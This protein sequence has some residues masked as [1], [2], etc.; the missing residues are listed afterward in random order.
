M[1]SDFPCL[2]SQHDLNKVLK[3]VREGYPVKDRPQLFK[4]LCDCLRKWS[5]DSFESE[6]T[7]HDEDFQ[8]GAGE[9]PDVLQIPNFKVSLRWV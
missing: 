2:T 3:P 6:I 8:K 1:K 7:L 5:F 4:V 9:I